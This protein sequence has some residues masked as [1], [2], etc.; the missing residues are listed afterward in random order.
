MHMSGRWRFVG[1][2]TLAACTEPTI[3]GE[4]PAADTGAAADPG[5]GGDDP[6]D[7][8][9][10]DDTTSSGEHDGDTTGDPD[11]D[12]LGDTDDDTDHGT[13]GDTAGDATGDTDTDVDTD[14]DAD[15]GDADADGDGL[16]DEEED[17]LGTDPADPDTDGD[18]WNDGMETVTDPLDPKD[19]PY[20]GG[21]PIGECRDDV[22]PTTDAVGGVATDFS[23]ADQFEDA[24]RLYAFCDRAVL[25]VSTA[26]WASTAREDTLE[27][28]ALYDTYADRGLMIVELLAE[29]THGD[30]PDHDDLES[31]ASRMDVTFPV[32]ADPDWEVSFRFERDGSLPSWTLMA[33]GVVLASMDAD[34]STADIESVLP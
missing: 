2:L 8:T 33:P 4:D 20:T 14:T 12:P 3:K 15:P 34:L 1:L 10:D 11:D 24:V 17:A 21:W 22:E 13:T 7:T 6:A 31:W 27:L 29:D 30:T 32:L 5:P 26:G 19:H 25:I 18:G 23:L 28:Q 16:T 9:D